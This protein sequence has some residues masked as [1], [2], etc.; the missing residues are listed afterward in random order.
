[1]MAQGGDGLP[2]PWIFGK[3]IK[4]EE[5][6]IY[7]TIIKIKSNQKKLFYSEHSKGISK[8]ISCGLN[9]SLQ[10]NFLIASPWKK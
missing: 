3:I 9:V 7:Q 10:A 8:I 2:L 6:K 4:F 5:K 1:M